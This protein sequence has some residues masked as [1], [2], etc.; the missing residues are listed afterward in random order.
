MGAVLL[1][2]DEKPTK[3]GAVRGG[4]VVGR[5]RPVASRGRPLTRG[6]RAALVALR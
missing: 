3:G 1:Q 5:G 2:E 4:R 6:R